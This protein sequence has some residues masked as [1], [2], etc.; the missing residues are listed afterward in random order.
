MTMSTSGDDDSD[1]EGKYD[2]QSEYDAMKTK[3]G[4]EE[5]RV[6]LNLNRLKGCR[7]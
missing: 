6:G 2:R 4:R 5:D 3:T 7:L 1:D